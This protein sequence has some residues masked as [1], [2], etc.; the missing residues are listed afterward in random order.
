LTGAAPKNPKIYHITHV[1][2]LASI[3][4]DGCIWSDAE[5]HR[6]RCNGPIIGINRI[7]H[8]RLF[9]LEVPSHPELH[10]GDCV[11]FYFCPRSVMLYIIHRG[12]HQDLEYQGGQGPIIHLETDVREVADWAKCQGVRWAFTLSNAGS[13]YFESRCDLDQ[14]EE[15]NW[16]AVRTNDW[17]SCKE[18]KQAEF[19]VE[20]HFPWELVQRIGVESKKVYG[21]VVATMGSSPH[22]PTIE[23]RRDW[24]Y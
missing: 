19:L 8:R 16:S 14:L 20:D 15:I 3:I 13:N 24:Y 7:K 5:I 6:R 23:L 9:D 11:P 21:Q 4:G 18:G 12:N 17:A 1:D 10:V 2:N 22:R